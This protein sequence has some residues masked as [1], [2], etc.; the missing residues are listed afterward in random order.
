VNKL[1]LAGAAVLAFA[2]P[3]VAQDMAVDAQGNVYVMTPVQQSAYDTWPPDRQ[4]MYTGWPD[5]YKTYY[6]TLTPS[7]Q[8][9]WW[10]LTD[11]QRAKVYAMT[12]DMRTTTWASIEKQMMNTPSASASMMAGASTA[13]ATMQFVSNAMVQSVPTDAA[14]ANPPICKAGQQDNCIN[15]WEAGKRGAG[16]NRPLDHWPGKPASEMPGH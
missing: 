3:A 6:W 7:Q 4:T 1:I 13:G 14:P 8:T 11:E 16:V 12:P 2:V 9:G 15:A 5:T 10:A